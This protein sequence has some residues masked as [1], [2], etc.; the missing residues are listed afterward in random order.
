VRR[1]SP[2]SR[3][4]SPSTTEGRAIA[5]KQHH[6]PSLRDIDELCTK[7]SVELD[8]SKR[9]AYLH[10]IQQ[11]VHERVIA[12]P[13]WQLTLLAGVG[14]RIDDAQIG[15]IGSLPWTSP[16][17]DIMLGAVRGEGA[18]RRRAPGRFCTGCRT[19]DCR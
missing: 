17:E 5:E 15:G 4:L 1:R 9:E 12:A 19:V 16:Y 6:S 3:W 8:Q 11:L 10:K 13:I 7:Q 14:P 2:P 18:A